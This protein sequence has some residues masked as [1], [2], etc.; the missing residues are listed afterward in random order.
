MMVKMS[1][2]P[3]EGWLTAREAAARLGVKRASLYAYVSRGVLGRHTGP[4]GR[5]SRYDAAEVDA[6]A[7][8]GRPRRANG[9]PVVE[10]AVASSITRIPE[11]SDQRLGHR[12]RGRRALAL[13][14]DHTFE[15]VAGWVLDGRDEPIELGPALGPEPAEA[16]APPAGDVL[17][18][19]RLAVERA[20]LADPLRQDLSAQSLRASA[21]RLLRALV[22]ASGPARGPVPDLELASGES[23]RASA[24]GRLAV[25]L[26]PDARPPRWATGAINAALVLLVDHELATSTLAARVAASTRADPYAC[27]VAALA[28]LAGP[29]HGTASALV[30][31]ALLAPDPVATLAE[32][33][34]GSGLAGFGHKLYSGIDPRAVALL[35]RVERAAPAHPARLAGL[36][37]TEAVEHRLAMPPNVDLGLAVL[38]AAAGLD[39]DAGPVIFAVART[40]GWLAHVAEEYQA[41]PLRFRARALDVSR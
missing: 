27:V 32:L 11:G 13:A 36:A 28:T 24:A 41:P 7:R 26:H 20:A 18:R 30:R 17:A 2:V 39:A 35:E 16:T 37:L 12:Y 34:G 3:E 23:V 14:G 6:L 19:M 9:E 1:T 15:Q 31:R 40:A 29:L 8:R 38:T 5:T 22:D 10:V 4:D 21:A 33:S 25:A